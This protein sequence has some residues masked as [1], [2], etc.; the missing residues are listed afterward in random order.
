MVHCF[1]IDLQLELNNIHTYKAIIL[2]LDVILYNTSTTQFQVDVINN[3]IARKYIHIQKSPE[4]IAILKPVH[5][6]HLCI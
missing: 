6:Q 1:Y 3:E 2:D 4:K 5:T